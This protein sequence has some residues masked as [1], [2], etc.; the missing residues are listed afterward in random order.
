[1]MSAAFALNPDNYHAKPMRRIKIQQRG[2]GKVRYADIP[3]YFDRAMTV[4][5]E[6]FPSCPP[7]FARTM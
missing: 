1:M 7:F 3:T 4:L 6:L 2:N 5:G